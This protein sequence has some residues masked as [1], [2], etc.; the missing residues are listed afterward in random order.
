MRIKAADLMGALDAVVRL[1]EPRNTI[2]ILGNVL[3]AQADGR[4]SVSVTNLDQW[5]T[6]NCPAEGSIEAVTVPALQFHGLVRALPRD[7]TIELIPKDG[8]LGVNCGR[9][10][11]RLQTLPAK[12][13]PARLAPDGGVEFTLDA[14]AVER[15]FKLPAFAASDEE[16]RFY[17]NRIC[18]HSLGARIVAVATDS[19]RLAKTTSPLSIE[20]PDRI[21]VPSKFV[22]Q[23][24]RLDGD[25]HIKV[26]KKCIE[27][28]TGVTT[29]A[30]RLIDGTFPDY[31][32][33]VPKPNESG[34]ECDRQQLANIAA[35]FAAIGITSTKKGEKDITT[36]IAAISWAAGEDHIK[37]TLGGQ[38]QGEDY[39]KAEISGTGRFCLQLTYL[40]DLLNAIP[41]KR[42]RFDTEGEYTPGRF[43]TP[44]DPDLLIVQMPTRG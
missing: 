23:I 31:E 42:V 14:V 11:Y 1:V 38:Q 29:I 39:A 10:R 41:G 20:W 34:F 19:H 30:S 33:A 18:L 22:G 17:L 13:F 40:H 35:R 32:R 26:S 15:L 6:S 27:A 5:G 12:D 16:T 2:P 43:S 8:I 4:L 21:T 25:V 3:L 36:R 24:L 28:S 37:L 7:A 9:S 44:D